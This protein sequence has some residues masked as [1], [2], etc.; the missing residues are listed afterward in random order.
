M[1]TFLTAV[2]LNKKYKLQNR[3]N[4]SCET[5]AFFDFDVEKWTAEYGTCTPNI[6]LN[7]IM[8]VT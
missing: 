4:A 5:A 1:P 8:L 7:K 3:Y 2:K 6:G